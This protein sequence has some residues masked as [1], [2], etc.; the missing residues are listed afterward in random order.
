MSTGTPESN[1]SFVAFISYSHR[2]AVWARW[3]QRALERY[4]LPADFAR[5]Q[6]LERKLGKV[7]RDREELATG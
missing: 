3:V 6:G 1:E 7:F 5:A 2:D 4:R